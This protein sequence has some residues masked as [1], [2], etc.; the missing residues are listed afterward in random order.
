M[1]WTALPEKVTLKLQ[2]PIPREMKLNPKKTV[3]VIVDMQKRWT[4]V[5]ESRSLDAVEGNAVL[6]KKAREAGVKVIFVQSVRKPDALEFTR[7]GQEPRLIEGTWETEIDDALQPL[8]SETVMKKYC[9]DPWARSPLYDI[10]LEHNILPT[11]TTAIVTGVSASV[12]ANAATIGFSNRHYMT[13]V[14]MDCQA[15]SDEV[16]EAL[17]YAKYSENSYAFTTSDLIEFTNEG[18]MSVQQ[19]AGLDPF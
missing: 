15:S 2:T 10:L 18:F 17:I 12:C 19:Q 11:D 16:E 8:E 13:L 1:A 5:P 6:L 9:H 14:P 7:F 4:T 3:L